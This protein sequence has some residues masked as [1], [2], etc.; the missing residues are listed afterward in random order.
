MKTSFTS[1]TV[2]SFCS[3]IL[4]LE[5]GC[6]QWMAATRNGYGKFGTLGVS[7]S[8]HRFSYRLFKGEIPANLVIDHL[9]RNQLCVNPKHLEAVTTR[10]NIRRGDGLAAQNIVKSQCPEGHI[11]DRFIAGTRRCSTCTNYKRQIRRKLARV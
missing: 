6:W 1:K 3:K 7:E 5:N 4:K 10:E 9:C 8:A 11:Y 2:S